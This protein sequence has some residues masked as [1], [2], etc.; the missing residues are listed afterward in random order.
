MKRKEFCIAIV[1]V[2]CI[3][4]GG[5]WSSAAKEKRN[6]NEKKFGTK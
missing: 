6:K 1:Y 4:V 5:S 2:L 3:T